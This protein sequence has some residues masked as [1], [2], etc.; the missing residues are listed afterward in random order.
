MMTNMFDKFNNICRRH[1]IKYWCL[2]GTLIGV[3]RHKGW[4]PWDGDIDLG[5]LEEDYNKLKEILPKELPRDMWFQNKTNDKYYNSDIG[6]IRD[7]NSCRIY[8]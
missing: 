4:V 5:I 3:V 1:N 2:G 6:K 7:L 8:K